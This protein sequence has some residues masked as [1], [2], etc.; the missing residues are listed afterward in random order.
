MRPINPWSFQEQMSSVQAEEAR[1]T[2]SHQAEQERVTAQHKAEVE[3]SL[4]GARRRVVSAES[5]W[6]M[7]G[8][9]NSG[10][11]VWGIVFRRGSNLWTDCFPLYQIFPPAYQLLSGLPESIL[12]KW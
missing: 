4:Q 9:E 6:W 3:N 11:F 10:F 1:K 7:V 12:G 2:I 8:D 5:G